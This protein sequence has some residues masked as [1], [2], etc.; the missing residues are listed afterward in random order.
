VDE[1]E[2]VSFEMIFASIEVIAKPLGARTSRPQIIEK[3]GQDARAPSKIGGFAI[4]CIFTG[5]DFSCLSVFLLFYS[6]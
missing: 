2:P 6:Q 4:A 3:C 5:F 1:F